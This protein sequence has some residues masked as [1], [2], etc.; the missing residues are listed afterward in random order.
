[1]RPGGRNEHE[2]QHQTLHEETS[3]LKTL[4]ANIGLELK[5]VKFKVIDY[6]SK[7]TVASLENLL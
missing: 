5:A 4:T 6:F 3:R 7:L 1:M 2:G